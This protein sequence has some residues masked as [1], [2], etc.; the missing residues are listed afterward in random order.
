MRNTYLAFH[1][2][3]ASDGVFQS[4]D[5]WRLKKRQLAVVR[6][7]AM[8]TRAGYLDVD[9]GWAVMQVYRRQAGDG[10]F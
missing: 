2:F 3:Y 6:T 8:S 1:I 9:D 4:L 7:L 5:P 10:V